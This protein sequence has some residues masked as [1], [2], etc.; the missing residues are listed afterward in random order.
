MPLWLRRRRLAPRLQTLRAPMHRPCCWGWW[1]PGCFRG[2]RVRR[3]RVA[4]PLRARQS[5]CRRQKWRAAF[6]P[7]RRRSAATA[8]PCMTAA[9]PLWR[10]LRRAAMASFWSACQSAACCGGQCCAAAAR[11]MRRAMR[12]SCGRT[13]RRRAMRTRA[14][15]PSGCCGGWRRCCSAK[16]RQRGAW[17]R[18]SCTSQRWGTVC[19]LVGEGG[20]GTSSALAQL[21][22][23]RR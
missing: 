10:H 21:L 13:R 6:V 1:S 11:A 23:W 4:A 18:A 14:R 20:E 12:R 2:W 16:S 7:H 3:A 5:L 15:E 22:L 17:R 9:L 8:L 19:V